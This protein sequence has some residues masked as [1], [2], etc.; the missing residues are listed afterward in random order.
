MK[1]VLAIA[2]LVVSSACIDTI[3]I[4]PPSEVEPTATLD[5]VQIPA[6]F[7][8][9]TT[10]PVKLVIRATANTLGDAG[11]GLVTVLNEEGAT[12]F[13]GPVQAGE[14]L[15]IDFPLASYQKS[16][17]VSLKTAGAAEEVQQNVEI[18]TDGSAN[19]R[20]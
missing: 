20:L 19:I 3:V 2:A 4:N 17:T 12:L 7:R 8:F 10:R 14:P 5:T 1:H 13:R 6:D 15:S 11:A 16:V 18:A 9:E